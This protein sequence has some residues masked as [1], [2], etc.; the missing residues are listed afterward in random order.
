MLILSDT[1]LASKIS[2]PAQ[3]CLP[4]FDCF[5]S[6]YNFKVIPVTSYPSS[7]I[8]AATTDESTPP[9]MA[10]TTL[11]S[12]LDLLIPREFIIKVYNPIINN[13]P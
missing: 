13:I 5:V 7:F 11:V 12:F 10:T 8:N 1:L 4:S 6:S 9:D 3:H 2:C